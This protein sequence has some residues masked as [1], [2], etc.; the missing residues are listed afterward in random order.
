[1]TK[2]DRQLANK[3]LAAKKPADDTVMICVRVPRTLREKFQSVCDKSGVSVTNA[4]KTAMSFAIE[5]GGKK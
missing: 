4:I 3:M 5:A 2:N 1:M